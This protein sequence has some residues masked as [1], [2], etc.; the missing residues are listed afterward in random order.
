MD[1]V[2]LGARFSIATNRLQFCGPADA[3]PVLYR[4][5]VD[6]TDLGPAG[7]ALG[8]FEALYPYL[9]AIGRH[10]GLPPLDGRVVEA[11]WIGN[12]LLD[13]FDRTEFRAILDALARRGLPS[14]V[15]RELADGLPPDP[16][17]HHVFHVA[18]VGVGA[19]TGHVATTLPNMEACRP[20]WGKVVRV[21]P[22]KL[23]VEGPTLT[24]LD[25]ALVL[26]SPA[27][28]EVAYDPRFLPGVSVGRSV[29]VH[30]G[31]AAMELDPAQLEALERY[32]LR[33]LDRANVAHAAARRVAESGGVG[34][35]P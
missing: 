1:G 28:S 15:A 5:V 34:R 30:W 18:Y 23:L 20:S 3:E 11:Y 27:T 2:R 25:G 33:S 26:G 16:L 10:A 21:G 19:V 13:G 24:A 17:P 7:V 9:E 22:A 14:F 35:G 29:A 12:E 32:T 8:R 31:W 4:A 6:G